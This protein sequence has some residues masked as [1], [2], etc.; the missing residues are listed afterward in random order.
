MTTDPRKAALS[1]WPLYLLLL[2]YLA[3][4]VHFDA[5]PLM[6]AT[7]LAKNLGYLGILAPGLVV[8]ATLTYV[9]SGPGLR[10]E[11][12]RLLSETDLFGPRRRAAL[13][14]NL[15]CFGLLWWLLAGL[16]EQ[17]ARGEAPSGAELSAFLLFALGSA[18][19]LLWAVVPAA[20]LRQLGP[21][22]AQV[23]GLGVLAGALAWGAGV[24][25]GELWEHMQRITLYLVFSLMLPFSENIAFAP[26]DA[27]IGT[28]TFLVE[29]AP[30][31][32]GIEGIGLITVVM[33]VFLWS[34]RERLRFP[35]ALALL[36]LAV[37]LVF[38]FNAVRIALLIAVGVYISPEVALSGFH[39]KAG[40]L[41]FCA[42]ALGL[43]ALAQRSRFFLRP[44]ALQL[45]AAEA[46]AWNPTSTYLLPLLVLIATSLATALFSSAGFDRF[47]A[48]RLLTVGLALYSQHK[49]LPALRW[50]PS[51]SAP[52]IGLA[53]FALWLWLAPRGKQADARALQE[54]I[55]TL[56]GPWTGFWLATRALGATV[57]V[58]IAEELAFRGF[59]LRRLIARD[60]SEVPKT[61]LT[62]LAL[63]GSSLAFAALH[64][65][66]LAAACL[67]GVAYALAQ[68]L[69]GRT[70]DAIVAHA[71]TNGC[72]AAYVLVADAYWLWL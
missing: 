20:A 67:A 2:E 23:L 33:S 15:V 68:Q 50:H 63:V 40:W 10:R 69:R 57:I 38:F 29:V 11:L 65:G 7:G 61:R 37:C 66:A 72:I 64:P 21:R 6:A 58:P 39:S 34:A 42:I 46:D 71:V 27:L 41:F 24:A 36:P 60:F 35:R 53:V 26:N 30:E 70:G 59:V 17:V 31:C 47:Y 3:I 45:S 55:A 51:L 28:E 19:A 8:V 48:L 54:Q 5:K 32:S 62:P 18:L 16:L 14:A 4:S 49:H 9:L 52:A 1:M 43:I 56:G 22:A 44:E 12:T 25:S 13:G